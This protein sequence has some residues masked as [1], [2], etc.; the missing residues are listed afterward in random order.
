MSLWGKSKQDIQQIVKALIDWGELNY[1]NFPW[2]SAA[3]KFHAIVAEIMLQRTKAEQVLVVYNN[4]VAEYKTAE[5][6]C[7]A[8]PEKI[9]ELLRSLGLNWRAK[10]LLEFS[11]E[12]NSRGLI[13][14]KFNELTKLPAVG[15]YVASAFLS[16]HQNQRHSLIDANTVRIWGRIFGFETNYETRRKKWFKELVDT[17]TPAENFRKFNYALLDFSN[18][19]CAKKPLC[20]KCPISKWCNYFSVIL[21]SDKT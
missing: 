4:F 15:Q 6:V 9:I 14:D 12:I 8:S 21:Y 13:P 2:R 1:R 20:E 5:D 18:F 17:I 7:S 10:K 19:V 16:L 11:S 3:N